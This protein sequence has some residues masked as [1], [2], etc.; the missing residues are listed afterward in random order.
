M[1]ELLVDEEREKSI[2]KSGKSLVWLSFA[3]TV[4]Q[5]VQGGGVLCNSRKCISE[6]MFKIPEDSVRVHKCI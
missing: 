5:I 3:V 2:L 4:F 1:L 6:H